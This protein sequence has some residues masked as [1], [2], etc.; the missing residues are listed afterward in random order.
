MP[1][2]SVQVAFPARGGAAFH[3]MKYKVTNADYAAFLAAT[4]WKPQEVAGWLRHWTK[5]KAVPAGLGAR[6]VVWVSRGDAAAFCSAHGARLP[7]EWEWQFSAQGND[8]RRWWVWHAPSL[9]QTPRFLHGLHLVPPPIHLALHVEAALTPQSRRA[10]PHRPWGMLDDNET[11]G[12]THRP[13]VSHAVPMPAPPVVSAY[14]AG[15]SAAGVEALVG[16]VAEWTDVCECSAAPLSRPRLCF[17]DP[18]Y[19]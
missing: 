11:L 13:N 10:R 14:P 18:T 6:P 2:H 7:H 15:A 9:R 3:I 12:Y 1:Q 5:D 16:S 8:G 17:V 4:G 19:F